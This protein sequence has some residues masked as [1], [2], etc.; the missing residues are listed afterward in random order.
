[1]IDEDAPIYLVDSDKCG[2]DFTETEAYR[3][4]NSHGKNSREAFKIRSRKPWYRVTSTEVPDGFLTYM[5][6]DYPRFVFNSAGAT[7]TNSVHRVFLKELSLPK[8]SPYR[9]TIP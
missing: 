7:S 6:G 3:Y 2:G 9:S 4:L 1:M 8:Q 5:I